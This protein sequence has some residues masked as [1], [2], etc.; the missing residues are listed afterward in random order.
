MDI[1]ND[2]PGEGRIITLDS[3]LPHCL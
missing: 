3:V 2:W 1:M